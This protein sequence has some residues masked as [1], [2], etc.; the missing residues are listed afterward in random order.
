MLVFK[1]TVVSAA[2]ALTVG[3]E[4]V[5][6]LPSAVSLALT[7]SATLRVVRESVNAFSV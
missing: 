5:N 4:V 3:V 1:S 6:L 7:A 2:K